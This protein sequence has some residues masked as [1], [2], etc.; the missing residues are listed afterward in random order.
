MCFW[1][2]SVRKCVQL[3]SLCSAGR[4]R[5][6]WSGR[7]S[8]WKRTQS[9]LFCGVYKRCV[10]LF[11]CVPLLRILTFVVVGWTWTL[12]TSWRSWRGWRE[13]N[14]EKKT[15]KKNRPHIFLFYRFL[16]LHFLFCYFSLRGPVELKLVSDPSHLLSSSCRKTQIAPS[17]TSSSYQTHLS[18]QRPHFH[19]P[20]CSPSLAQFSLNILH[21]CTPLSASDLPQPSSLPTAD[22]TRFPPPLLFAFMPPY[23]ILH[24]RN[25]Q[26][27]TH[28]HTHILTL[29]SIIIHRL[30]PH[31]DPFSLFLSFPGRWWRDWTQGTSWWTSEWSHVLPSSLTT[32]RD[33]SIEPRA[34]CPLSSCR[35]VSGQ[36]YGL[37]TPFILLQTPATSKRRFSVI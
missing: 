23:Y 19:F 31:S 32:L 16:F 12:R 20:L 10:C 9:E 18:H 2:P 15:K 33:C 37:M 28:T 14:A 22:A 13:G 34:K 24:P 35:C 6:W 3:F 5:V 21:L 27:D 25:T 7:T 29:S 8:W 26:T 36:S 4:P 17:W 1:S 30:F 11:W